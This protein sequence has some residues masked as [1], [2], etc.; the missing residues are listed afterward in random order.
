MIK[1]WIGP[2]N[3][4]RENSEKLYNGSWDKRHNGMSIAGQNNV[5][6]IKIGKIYFF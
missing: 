5:R 3:W 6:E 4:K 2:N 1:R